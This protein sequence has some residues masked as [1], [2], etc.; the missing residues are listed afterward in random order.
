MR[1]RNS[2]VTRRKNR[3]GSAPDPRRPAGVANGVAERP[4]SF[5]R[6]RRMCTLSPYNIFPVFARFARYIY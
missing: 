1:A 3:G 6:L 5:K 4:H 2:S